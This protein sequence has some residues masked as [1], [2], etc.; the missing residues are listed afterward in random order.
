MLELIMAKI[1]AEIEMQMKEGRPSEISVKL[2]NHKIL[3]VSSFSRIARKS[4]D[5]QSGEIY[6]KKEIWKGN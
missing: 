6:F 2:N 1:R 4:I 3:E 5:I